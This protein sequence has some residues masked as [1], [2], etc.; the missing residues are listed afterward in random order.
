MIIVKNDIEFA[1]KLLKREYQRSGLSAQIRLKKIAKKS[2]RRREKERAAL[3]RKRMHEKRR[4]FYL[5]QD[6]KG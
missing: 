3:R 4:R 2:L 1:L 5:D 6:N